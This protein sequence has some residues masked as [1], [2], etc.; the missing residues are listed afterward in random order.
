MR[1][2]ERKRNRQKKALCRL[3]LYTWDTVD[4]FYPRAL[5]GA[6]ASHDELNT[7]NADRGEKSLAIFLVFDGRKIWHVIFPRVKISLLP[8]AMWD[9]FKEM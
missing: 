5:P 6:Q 2:K 3:V 8:Q 4:M 9:P 1:K 7:R